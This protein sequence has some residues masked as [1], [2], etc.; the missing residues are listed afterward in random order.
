MI[1]NLLHLE[2]VRFSSPNQ[3]P[4]W[5]RKRGVSLSSPLCPALITVRPTRAEG[6][7]TG[8]WGTL[9]P[10]PPLCASVFS[11]PWWAGGSSI[12]NLPRFG[13][14]WDRGPECCKVL[15]DLRMKQGGWGKVPPAL[16]L[17]G[18]PV[19]LPDDTHL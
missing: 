17:P 3:T 7:G 10:H 19:L 13:E 4:G 12:L 1:N 18:L 14:G 16:P 9:G 11:L 8:G 2:P 5:V 15:W 6:R